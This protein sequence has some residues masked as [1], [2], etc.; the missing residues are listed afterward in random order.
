MYEYWA[1]FTINLSQIQV[2]DDHDGTPVPFH[3]EAPFGIG[4]SYPP[5][6]PVLDLATP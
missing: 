6:G 1:T 2:H 5:I 4:F 3:M